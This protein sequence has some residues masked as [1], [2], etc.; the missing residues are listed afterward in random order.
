[1]R[2]RTVL[3]VVFWLALLIFVGVLIY[4]LF[5]SVYLKVTNIKI[6]GEKYIAENDLAEKV[7]NDLSGKILWTISKNNLLLVRKEEIRKD[8]LRDFR[9]ARNVE[10][11]KKFPHELDVIVTERI[12]TILFQ[13]ANGVFF[14]DEKAVAYDNADPKADKIKNYDLPFLADADGKNVDLGEQVL[15]GDY[16]EY[17]TAIRQKMKDRT[18]IEI[19][20]DFT[21]PSLVS[22]DIRVRTKE[23]WQ[24][25]FN[26]SVP[27]DKEIEMLSAV[28]KNEIP[29]NER[30]DLDY[31]DLRIDNKVYYKFRDGTPEET[32]RLAQ[33]QAEQAASDTTAQS[34][35]TDSSTS[36]KKDKKNH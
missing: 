15:N 8:I 33:E 11:R 35:S 26:E 6:S 4:V 23:G 18:D 7:Q 29:Q 31:V 27:L 25:F 16:L 3:R 30:A 20:N 32:A 21:T 14:L 28:L 1:M 36:G 9:Q 5:F 13:G 2:R 22:R 17:L 10:I 19:A 24:I 34:A 12:P